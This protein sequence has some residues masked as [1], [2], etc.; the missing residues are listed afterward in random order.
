MQLEFFEREMNRVQDRFNDAFGGQV[1][2]DINARHTAILAICQMGILARKIVREKPSPQSRDYLA[3][4]HRGRKAL[5]RLFNKMESEQLKRRKEH[6]ERTK[7]KRRC[8]GVSMEG[9]TPASRQRLPKAIEVYCEPWSEWWMTSA[10]L[11]LLDRHLECVEHEFA[12]VDGW[13]SPI[14]PRGG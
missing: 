14:R 5:H 2:C 4:F 7:Q 1:V 8:Q 11:P 3:G 13:P 9:R 12:S 6:V 10:G